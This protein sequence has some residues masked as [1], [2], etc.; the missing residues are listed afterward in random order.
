MKKEKAKTQ[1]GDEIE[2]KDVG[3]INVAG[4]L[5]ENCL[6]GKGGIDV[7]GSKNH[8]RTKAKQRRGNQNENQKRGE[9]PW[10]AQKG[11]GCERGGVMEETEK[12]PGGKG[13]HGDRTQAQKKKREKNAFKLQLEEG[14][15]GGGKYFGW[16]ER[17]GKMTGI[18]KP[19]TGTGGMGKK[20]CVGREGTIKNMEGGGGNVTSKHVRVGTPE[21]HTRK[22]ARKNS[23]VLGG[24]R[25]LRCER[26]GSLEEKSSKR[27]HKGKKRREKRRKQLGTILKKQFAR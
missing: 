3:G 1:K 4:R 10:R 8:G 6:F 18:R 22:G 17:G 21:R 26:R 25:K 12:P 19:V 23:K 11:E 16:G 15:C 14:L 13:S 20:T 5:K 27:Q 24:F 2:E 7:G 9:V